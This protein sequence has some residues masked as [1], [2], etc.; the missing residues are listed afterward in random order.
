MTHQDGSGILEDVLKVLTLQEPERLKSAIKI[1]LNAATIS[2]PGAN[3]RWT[4]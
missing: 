1:L 2:I 3:H 4:M